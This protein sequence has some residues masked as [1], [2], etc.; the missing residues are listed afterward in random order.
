[1]IEAETLARGSAEPTI[2]TQPVTPQDLI[3]HDMA[4]HDLAQKSHATEA[5]MHNTRRSKAQADAA[6]ITAAQKR[7]QLHQAL[8]APPEPD[9]DQSGGPSDQ[10]ADNA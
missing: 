2:P 7:L 8:T 4:G 3:A 1:M 6:E 5:A 10:D 9:A